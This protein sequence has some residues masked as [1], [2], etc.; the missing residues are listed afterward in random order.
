MY[1]NYKKFEEIKEEILYKRVTAWT[2]ETLTLDDRTVIEIVESEQDCCASA[3]GTWSNVKLDA[4]ITNVK[5]ENEITRPISEDYPD[6]E[7]ESFAT[8]I[9]YHNQNPIAQGSC[10]ADGGNGDYYYSVCSLKIK[11]IHYPVV[12]HE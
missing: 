10:Y 1:N 11:D 3:G 8:V 4:L 9:L 12:K 6:D 5:I 7:S 2:E